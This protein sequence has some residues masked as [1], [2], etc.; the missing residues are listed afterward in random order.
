MKKL[1]K[2]NQATLQKLKAKSKI[3]SNARMPSIKSIHKLL[4]EVGIQHRYEEETTNIV[5]RRTGQRAYV[6][7]R[8]EG[9]K[10]KLIQIDK[11]YIELDSSDSYY[12]L[13]TFGYANDLLDIINNKLKNN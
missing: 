8:H 2:Q 3:N 4:N 9:K 11:P 12:S 10:G 1:N 5:E 7:D 6:N 13:N